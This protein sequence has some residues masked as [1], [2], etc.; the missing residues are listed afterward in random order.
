MPFIG[1]YWAAP[2]DTPDGFWIDEG[3]Y[4][5]GDTFAVFLIG[6]R[7]IGRADRVDGGWV[8]LG[9]RKILSLEQAAL[10]MAK[11]RLATARKEVKLA[12]EMI[13][14]LASEVGP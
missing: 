10:A 7:E 13:R 3:T 14:D 2:K 8:P 12:E 4:P 1:P 11:A 6:K 5:N 9:K